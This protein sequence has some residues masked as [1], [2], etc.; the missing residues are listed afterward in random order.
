MGYSRKL[1]AFLGRQVRSLGLSPD[2]GIVEN[3]GDP[4]AFET[5]YWSGSRRVIRR[6][7]RSPMRFPFALW[8]RAMQ[9]C[10]LP[11]LPSG[12]PARPGGIGL[13]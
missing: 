12:R 5:P 10:G 1:R 4:F 9:P 7:R 13:G 11:R 6:G 2:G 8:N 3:T